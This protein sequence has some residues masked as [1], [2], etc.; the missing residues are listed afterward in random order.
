M[1]HGALPLTPLIPSGVSFRYNLSVRILSLNFA[2]HGSVPLAT[3]DG[4]IA[5]C[6]ETDV[7]AWSDADHR[8]GDHEVTPLLEKTLKDAGLAYSDLTHIACVTG[9]GGF[10]SIRSGV[11][12]A[13]VMSHEL[14]I[15]LAGIHLSDLYVARASL[16]PLPKGE[17]QGKSRFWLHST[18]KEQLFVRGGSIAEPTLMNIG[19]LLALLK[20]GDEWMGEL[21]DVQKS[22]VEALGVTA[23]TI[24]PLQEVLPGFLGKQK[25]EMQS[26]EPWYG[27]GW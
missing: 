20:K 22:A 14:K 6:S 4:H 16:Y 9:P 7:L 23:T 18:K 5:V 1:I 27:R 2:S 24:T 11:T 26:L 25:Y 17:G 13:N 8:M 3:G 12:M 21:I 10:T 15:P 19:D